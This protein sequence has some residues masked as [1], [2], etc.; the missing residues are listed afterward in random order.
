MDEVMNE[1]FREL[2]GDELAEQVEK[3]KRKPNGVEVL[4]P[5]RPV[6]T[7]PDQPKSEPEPNWW[8]R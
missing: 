6:R 7:E 4:K 8:D 5:K 2:Y 1:K 3:L